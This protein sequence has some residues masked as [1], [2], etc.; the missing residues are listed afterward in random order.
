MLVRFTSCLAALIVVA[1]A[2]QP[3]YGFCFKKKACCAPACES[4]CD[5]APACGDAAP[6]CE[7]A[8]PA[9]VEKKVMVPEWVTET[10]TVK[11]TEMKKEEQERKVTVMERQTVTEE[12]TKKVCKMVPETKTK[13][14]NYTVCKP[15]HQD[16]TVKY[17]VMAPVTEKKTGVKKV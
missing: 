7:A 15:D 6:A 10:R 9:M 8:A 4:G 5:A 2:G 1:A 11:V 14:V 13:T 3:A 12:R 16:K 17:T